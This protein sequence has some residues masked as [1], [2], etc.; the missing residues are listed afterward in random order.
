MWREQAGVSAACYEVR[1]GWIVGLYCCL[2]SQCEALRLARVLRSQK[3]LN[4]L[5]DL[6]NVWKLRSSLTN[7]SEKSVV[8][9]VPLIVVYGVHASKSLIVGKVSGVNVWQNARCEIFKRIREIIPSL[10]DKLISFF[11]L[12]D[13]FAWS[14]A[15][16]RDPCRVLQR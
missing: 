5:A 3:F 11:N 4:L 16:L 9:S 6:C 1:M 13:S 14:F 8:Q 7:T 2:R 15:E 10:N 12:S